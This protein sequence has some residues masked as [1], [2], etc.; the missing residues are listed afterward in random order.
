MRITCPSCET[1]YNLP[2]GA[3]GPNG[4]SV[5]CKRCA[6]VWVAKPVLDIPF[7]DEPAARPGPVADTPLRGTIPPGPEAEEPPR[8]ESGAR[9]RAA[10]PAEEPDPFVA[11]AKAAF[12]DEPHE[13]AAARPDA[14]GV[15]IDS[16]PHGFARKLAA[17][18][19][20]VERAAAKRRRLGLKPQRVTRLVDLIRPA[21]GP[22][23]LVLAIAMLAGAVIA[24]DRVVAAV[25]DLAGLYRLAGLPVNLRGLEFVDVTTHRE[26]ENGQP[27]LVVEGQISNVSGRQ[28]PV[29]AVRLA[30]KGEN[31]GEIYAW[32][33]EPKAR[34]LAAGETVRFRTRLASPPPARDI[35]LRFID[36]RATQAGMQ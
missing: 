6:T 25:P 28:R 18:K 5:K 2:D 34:E 1:S 19:A 17:E 30:L 10:A 23:A 11:A 27:V 14:D 22:A 15:V 7:A 35:E 3:I 24:R 9:P 13:P 21:F 33:M 16:A 32:A 12:L 36:R 26:T 20:S 29:P 8:A 31:E 4:R